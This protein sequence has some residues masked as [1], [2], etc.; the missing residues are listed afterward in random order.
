MT[1]CRVIARCAINITGINEKDILSVFVDS[2]LTRC[3]TGQSPL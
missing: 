2:G 3:L 1:K